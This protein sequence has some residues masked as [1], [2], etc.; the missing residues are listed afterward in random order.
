[1]HCLAL[2]ASALG[3][4]ISDPLLQLCVASSWCIMFHVISYLSRCGWCLLRNPVLLQTLRTGPRPIRLTI[5]MY[6]SAALRFL[7]FCAFSRL[8]KRT[9]W[10]SLLSFTDLIGLEHIKVLVLLK[11]DLQ[12]RINCTAGLHSRLI[13]Q[14]WSCWSM[15]IGTQ[16]FKSPIFVSNYSNYSKQNLSALEYHLLISTKVTYQRIEGLLITDEWQNDVW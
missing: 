16:F 1:M 6:E 12:T 5:K 2:T 15:T 3:S 11:E 9:R 8:D 10:G 7:L 13:L 14:T 4:W